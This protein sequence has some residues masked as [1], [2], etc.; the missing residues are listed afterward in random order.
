M[1]Q[2]CRS[3]ALNLLFKLAHLLSLSTLGNLFA[4]VFNHTISELSAKYSTE[5]TPAGFAFGVAWGIIYIWNVL[6]NGYLLVSLVLPAEA[7]PVKFNPTLAPKVLFC[8]IT[9]CYLR[10]CCCCKNLICCFRRC[11]GDNNVCLQNC[12]CIWWL[13]DILFFNPC[14]ALP[15]FSV[16][17][18]TL[19]RVS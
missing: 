18:L 10:Q 7:S 14:S 5:V 8:S 9:S 2:V 16:A 12:R 3:Y 4:D 11:E 19:F 15:P 1:Q 17:F 6:I 13:K